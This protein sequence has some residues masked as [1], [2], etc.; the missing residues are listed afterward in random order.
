MSCTDAIW[1]IRLTSPVELNK[2]IMEDAL[3]K[4]GNKDYMS[5][6][7][8]KANHLYQCAKTGSP[9]EYGDLDK[10]FVSGFLDVMTNWILK[11]VNIVT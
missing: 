6:I 1:Q 8:P 4:G 10:R 9:A 11:H 7:F 3:E 5:K 2:D